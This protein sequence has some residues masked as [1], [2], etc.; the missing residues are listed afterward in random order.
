MLPVVA[1]HGAPRSG[2]SWIG[3]L[4]NS[5]AH[6]AY[7]YQPFFAHAF[8]GRVSADSTG[9]QFE[10][11]FEDLTATADPFVLQQ[12]DAS[13]AAAPISF[14]KQ[15]AR[16]LVYKEVRFHHLLPELLAKVDRLVAIGVVRD[17]RAVLRSWA[18]APREFRSGWSFADEWRDAARKNA[19]LEENWFGFQRWK[20]LASLFLQLERSHPSRFRLVRYEDLLEQGEAE[21]RRL[22]GFCGIAFDEQSHRFW[23]ESTSRND[24]DPYGVFRHHH[25][26]RR[27]EPFDEHVSAT[28]VA[29]LEGTPLA[30]FLSYR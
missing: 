25:E 21:V 28:I 10:R 27:G 13:L 3:Q 16:H 12:G 15:A 24:D 7:R 26:E 22:F 14:P 1:I 20:E 4:F 29:E 8:R 11:F 30:R 9:V 5:S 19:G 18:S 17:P 2:T 23:L 6:V